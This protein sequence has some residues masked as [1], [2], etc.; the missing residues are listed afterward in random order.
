[1]LERAER[2][3]AQGLTKEQCAAALG[4]SRSKFFEI[5]EQNVDF[6]DA[7]KRGEALGNRRSNQRS[8]RK[9]NAGTR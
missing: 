7:I 1:M 5:Q 8:L 2:A 4:I 3:M 9:C 6:L